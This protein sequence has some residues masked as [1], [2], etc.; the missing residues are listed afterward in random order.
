MSR[1]GRILNGIDGD[2]QPDQVAIL[3]YRPEHREAP[4]AKLTGAH[5]PTPC[6]R[7]VAHWPVLPRRVEKLSILE[8]D[9]I[10]RTASKALGINI[11]KGNRDNCSIDDRTETRAIASCVHERHMSKPLVH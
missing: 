11:T 1:L 3:Q 7:G 4:L 2:A 10:K 5:A 6:K 8:V 9:A